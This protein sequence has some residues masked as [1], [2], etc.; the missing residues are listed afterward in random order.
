MLPGGIPELR[1]LG[2]VL[3]RRE[4]GQFCAG[5]DAKLGEDVLEVSLYRVAGQKQPGGDLRV[6]KPLGCEAHYRD[7][8]RS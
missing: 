7:F 4:S 8:R 6:G 1:Y 5:P 3:A 2:N